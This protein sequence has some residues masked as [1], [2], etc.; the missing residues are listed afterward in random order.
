[1]ANEV[2]RQRPPLDDPP[3]D[4]SRDRRDVHIGVEPTAGPPIGALVIG[5][6]C[7]A[8]IGAAFALAFAPKPGR[9]FRRQ[10]AA[11]ANGL[12][13]RMY[14]AGENMADMIARGRR[15]VDAGRRAYVRPGNGAAV[16]MPRL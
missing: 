1:M 9:D 12:R 16:D 15:A 6:A 11:S 10:M 4:E 2:D 3:S 5:I 8:A 7:G 13:R 14:A